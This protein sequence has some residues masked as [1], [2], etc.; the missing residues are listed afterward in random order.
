MGFVQTAVHHSGSV[1]L[2]TLKP[3]DNGPESS[4]ASWLCFKEYH[5]IENLGN[6]AVRWS[7]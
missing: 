7:R 5:R 4:T 3:H 6:S 1:G 2:S